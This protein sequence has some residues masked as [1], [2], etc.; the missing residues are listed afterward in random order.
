VAKHDYHWPQLLGISLSVTVAFGAL[1]YALSV[2]LTDEAA[3]AVFSTT[4][5]SLAYGGSILVGGGST[6]WIGRYADR[7]GI[8]AIVFTG[9][10]VG[11]LGMWGFGISEEPWQVIGVSWLVIGPA[12]ALLFYEPAYIAV[13]Q[14]FGATDRGRAISILTVFGGLAG[15]V[16]IPLTS[17]LVDEYGWRTTSKVL[18]VIVFVVGAVVSQ[19]FLPKH[20]GRQKQRQRGVGDTLRR[21]AG[22]RRFVWFTVATFLMFGAL[23]SVFFHRIAVFEEGGFSVRTVSTWAAVAGVL[24]F[25]GRW[26]ASF[27]ARRFGGVR[28]N[29]TVLLGQAVAVTMTVGAVSTW[30]LGGHFILFG[31]L[32]GMLLPL[33][34]VIMSDWYSGPEFGSI[35][36]AQWS[37][38]AIAGAGG[39]TVV[40]ALRDALSGYDIPMALLV[41]TFVAAAVA[42]VVAGRVSNGGREPQ[43]PG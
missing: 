29:A 16:F 41:A 26:G 2:L 25:P 20:E 23:Q 12:S 10:I 32:L 18:A 11:G 24:S 28:T 40:G 38:T 8:R 3:G 22:D 15:P 43:A 7:N 37:V 14:W 30:Q 36:G 9:A 1:L 19:V 31:L 17:W 27:L 5:L 42:T 33:R 6:F 4:T 21:L 34:A 35:M 39:A 13:N